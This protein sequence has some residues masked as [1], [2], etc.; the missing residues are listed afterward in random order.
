M[1]YPANKT[2]CPFV[3]MANQ[4]DEIGCLVNDVEHHDDGISCLVRWTSSLANK[5][6]DHVGDP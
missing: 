4:D 3:G 6:P 5:A 1:S 2:S